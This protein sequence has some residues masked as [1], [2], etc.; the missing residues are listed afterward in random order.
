MQLRQSLYRTESQP[1]YLDDKVYWRQAMSTMIK[2][3]YDAL[4]E[5]RASDE[6]IPPARYH[7]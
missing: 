2:E 1:N 5:T 6:G 3:V 4:G 7:S